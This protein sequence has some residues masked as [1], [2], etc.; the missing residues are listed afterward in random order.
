[1]VQCHLFFQEEGCGDRQRPPPGCSFLTPKGSGLT[2]LE[3]GRRPEAGVPLLGV[4]QDCR[5]Q[6]ELHLCL[7]PIRH[8]SDHAVRGQ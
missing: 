7:Q 8:L 3:K 5:G 2:P 4:L 6:S 1:M